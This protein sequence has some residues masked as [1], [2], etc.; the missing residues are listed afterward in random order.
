MPKISI[1]TPAY[2]DTNAKL[3]WLAEMVETVKKQSFT[4]WEL[5]IVDDASPINPVYENRSDDRIRLFRLGSRSGPSLARN[6]GVAVCEADALLPLDADDLLPTDDVLTK[7]YEE[8]AKDKTKTV[9]GDLQFLNGMNGNEFQPGRVIKLPEYTFQAALDPRALMPVTVLHSVD[10]HYKA[11]GWKPELD[12][13]LEDVEYW[14]A[15]AKAGFC[16]KHINLT[17]L[18]YRRHRTSRHSTLRASYEN[19]IAMRNKIME[20]HKDAYEGNC[21]EASMGCGCGGGGGRTTFQ[22]PKQQNAGNNGSAARM[23]ALDQV[24]NDQKVGVEYIGRREGTFTVVGAYTGI[25][26]TIDGVGSKFPAHVNDLPKFKLSGR[27]QDFRV[28]VTLDNASV[29]TAPAQEVPRANE[30]KP[31]APVVAAVEHLDR[32]A[33]QKFAGAV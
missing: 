13:G 17:T 24:G 32:R 1:I 30:Y 31:N 25:T 33:T 4:D 20:I 14:I 3:Q 12:K 9:Y 6:T 23:T 27:G 29:P 7:L 5:I 18:L 19:E 21:T 10:C 22:A 26:Y 11:G 2:I 15:A 16:G 8:W 28:G